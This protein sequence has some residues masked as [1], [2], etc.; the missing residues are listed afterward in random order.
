MPRKIRGDITVGN[1]EKNLEFHPE[2][3]ETQ[4]VVIHALIKD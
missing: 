2:Y 3:S 1:L 4:M